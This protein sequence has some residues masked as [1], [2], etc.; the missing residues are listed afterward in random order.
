MSV[1]GDF[2][3]ALSLIERRACYYLECSAMKSKNFTITNLN[4]SRLLVLLM[5][6]QV[7]CTSLHFGDLQPVY[8]C[9]ILC[10]WQ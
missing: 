9:S 7:V 4:I 10:L 5:G 3:G 8:N 6:V 2:D 1:V